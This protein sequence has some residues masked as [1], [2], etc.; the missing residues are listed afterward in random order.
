[1]Q[2][3]SNLSCYWSQ[4]IF[5]E[6]GWKNCNDL[7]DYLRSVSKETYAE[8]NFPGKAV[9]IQSV[10]R[11]IVTIE[12]DGDA[13]KDAKQMTRPGSLLDSLSTDYLFIRNRYLQN[14]KKLKEQLELI[15]R[16]STGI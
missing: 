9:F 1:M 12:L 6:Y 10:R 8:K 5:K 11:L 14:R 2:A 7:I 13:V 4:P 16:M 15:K 3:I